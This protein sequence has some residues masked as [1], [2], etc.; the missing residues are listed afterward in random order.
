M[1]TTSARAGRSAEPDPYRARLKRLRAELD[2]RGLDSLLV[3]YPRDIRYLTGFRGEDSVM[4]VGLSGK[5]TVISDSR[6][7]EELREFGGRVSIVMR[8]GVIGEA[9]VKVAR[10][11]RVRRLGLQAEHMT[12]S[13]RAGLS[14][15]MGAKRLRDTTGILR[16]LRAVKDASEIAALRRAIRL[17][18]ASL[19]AMLRTIRPGQTEAGVAA[20]LEMDMRS[21]G[22]ECVSFPSIVAAGANSSRPHYSPGSARVKKG[23]VLLIDWGAC[24]GGYR[25]DM[26]RTFAVGSW[27]R[28]MREVYGVVLDAH[29][30]A[31]DA[32]APGKTGK[33]IDAVARGIIAKAGHGERFGHGLGHG[34]GLDVHE[35]PGQIGRAHV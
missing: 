1:A 8:R 32:I 11:A 23:A 4:L 10:A 3:T 12:V 18:E 15:G 7:E 5:P 22:A 27:P 17:Q 31:I 33:Q 21:R 29:L 9:M 28:R 2:R 35:D 14:K 30:A 25:G 24:V 34:I 6:Y 26:T 16:G 13:T 20:R 19:K